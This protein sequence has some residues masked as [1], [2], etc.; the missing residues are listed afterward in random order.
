MW[1]FSWDNAYLSLS[2]IEQSAHLHTCSF[3]EIKMGRV[4]IN[5][6]WLCATA[7]GLHIYSHF[8]KM[9]GRK[10]KFWLCWWVGKSTL[11]LLSE[12]W[13]ACHS[14]HACA[15]SLAS[16]K[17]L[18]W[19]LWEWLS[20]CISLHLPFSHLRYNKKYC[21]LDTKKNHTDFE[22]GRLAS[23]CATPRALGQVM[24]SSYPICRL[25]AVS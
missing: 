20:F 23:D 16:M 14:V 5:C 21:M 7:S 17:F 15:P 11:M 13:A 4:V 3:C 22:F 25:D 1:E 10:V 8:P 24:M 18:V 12:Y 9:D 2:F 19:L 6:L